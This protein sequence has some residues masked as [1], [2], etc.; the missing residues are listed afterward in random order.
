MA[1]QKSTSYSPRFFPAPARWLTI[2]GNSTS[3]GMDTLFWP[4]WTPDTY[5]KTHMK[6]TFK[7][8]LNT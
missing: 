1:Q 6:K 5:G 4:L 3:K 2:A 8:K 7:I